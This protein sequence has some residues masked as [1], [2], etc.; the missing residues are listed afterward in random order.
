[1]ILYFTRIDPISISTVIIGILFL[2]YFYWICSLERVPQF[3]AFQNCPLCKKLTPQHYIHCNI[4][5]KC[6]SV[7][8]KHYPILQFCSL[9]SYFKRYICLLRG[10][11]VLNIVLFILLT[12]SFGPYIC[13]FVLFHLYILKSTYNRNMNN[14]YV[15]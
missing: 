7:D 2:N 12:I 3:H 15:K 1:M 6:V 14:I 9:E 10:L 11:I 13:V 4:C 8:K 5:K